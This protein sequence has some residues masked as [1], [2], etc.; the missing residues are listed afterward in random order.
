MENISKGENVNLVSSE[1]DFINHE[2]KIE[3]VSSEYKKK[4]QGKKR[5]KKGGTSHSKKRKNRILKKE[6]NL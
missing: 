5:A 2:E 6:Q 4:K 1:N 3:D